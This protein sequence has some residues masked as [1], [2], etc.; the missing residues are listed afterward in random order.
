MELPTANAINTGVQG[1]PASEGAE[2][3][4]W[5][6][7]AVLVCRGRGWGLCP[8]YASGRRGW[9]LCAV[10]T[11]GRRVELVCREEGGAGVQ[12]RR[13]GL[14]CRRGGWVLVEERGLVCNTRA[15]LVC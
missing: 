5:G 12:K 2:E 3:E 10:Y 1:R 14:V 13:V 11:S 8:A 9:G 6:W 4:R 15:G 7:S